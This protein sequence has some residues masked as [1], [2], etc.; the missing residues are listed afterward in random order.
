M[1]MTP[2]GLQPFTLIP[3]KYTFSTT[4]KTKQPIKSILLYEAESNTLMAEPGRSDAL[5]D[6]PMMPF[7]HHNY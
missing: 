5:Q 6:L 4:T 3:S 1:I 2:H 7:Q